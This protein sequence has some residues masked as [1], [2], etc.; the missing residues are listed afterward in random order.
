MSAKS[1][2]FQNMNCSKAQ[3]IQKLALLGAWSLLVFIAYSTLTPIQKRPALPTS[4]SAE[5]VVAFFV[6]GNAFCAAYP[7]RFY[8]ACSIVL[9]SAALL[10]VL[11][12][13]TPDRHGRIQDVIEKLAGGFVGVVVGWAFLRAAS[14]WFPFRS[15][16]ALKVGSKNSEV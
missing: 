13:L 5:H 14:R 1:N 7:R 16:E 10:E 12:L 4:T 8:F 2:R 11:Q 3:L 15:A 9:G 6:L